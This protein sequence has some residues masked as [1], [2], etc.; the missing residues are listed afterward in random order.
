[1]LGLTG[2]KGGHRSFEFISDLLRKLYMEGS[3]FVGLLSQRIDRVA[4]FA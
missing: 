2:D 4:E 3:L 1:M